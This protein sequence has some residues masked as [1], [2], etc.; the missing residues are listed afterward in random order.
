MKDIEYY[1]KMLD[2]RNP[3][4][5]PEGYFESFPQRI[6]DKIETV[7]PVIRPLRPWYQRP[8]M[9]VA[10]CL[11]SVLFGAIGYMAFRQGTESL[12]AD[13]SQTT[14]SQEKDVLDQAADYMMYD[15]QDFYAYCMEE[16]GE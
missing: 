9:R 12:S 10:A 5:V 3:F 7:E 4:R 1:E 16:R 2:K 11:L 8:A 14:L 15:K 6:M 13:S